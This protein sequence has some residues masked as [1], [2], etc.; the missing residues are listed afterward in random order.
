MEG[1]QAIMIYRGKEVFTQETFSY[2][3]AKPGDYVVQAV[4]DDA[5]DCMLPAC[6]SSRCAQMGEPYSHRLDPVTGRWRATYNTFKR[7]LDAEDIWEYCGKC[8]CGENV[9]RGHEPVYV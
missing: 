8:F 5:M 3:A 6:M 4:V 7:C 1:V 2:A 9:E